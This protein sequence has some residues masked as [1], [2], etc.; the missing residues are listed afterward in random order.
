MVQELHSCVEDRFEQPV[1]PGQGD[2]AASTDTARP[3]S[4]AGPTAPRSS[5]LRSS[6]KGHAQSAAEG[7]PG[8]VAQ[9]RSASPW[10][11]WRVSGVN[12]AARATRCSRSTSAIWISW[13]STS[14]TRAMATQPPQPGSA[15]SGCGRYRDRELSLASSAGCLPVPGSFGWFTAVRA[16]RCEVVLPCHLQGDPVTDLQ[17]PAGGCGQQF[18][19]AGPVGPLNL[20][21][22]CQHRSGRPVAA[23]P[24]LPHLPVSRPTGRPPPSVAARPAA[25]QEAL[26]PASPGRA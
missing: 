11:G 4:A 3:S 23:A 20:V 7:Y 19:A 8:K 24:S 1:R 5:Q 6:R 18:T 13:L 16:H 15:E 12:S 22:V 10:R 9:T 2:G 26:M 14:M 17:P 25:A 21:E